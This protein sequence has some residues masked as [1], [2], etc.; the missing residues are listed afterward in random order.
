MFLFWNSTQC[1]RAD[2]L[3]KTLMLGKIEDRGS[4]GWMASLTQ[5]TWVWANSKK[6]W[7]TGKPACCSPWCHKQSDVIEESEHH[8]HHKLIHIYSI[9][10][11]STEHD[12]FFNKHFFKSIVGRRKVKDN[13]KVKFLHDN[14]WTIGCNELPKLTFK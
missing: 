7:R 14:T 10:I 1:K 9:N 5:Q 12:S 6:Q 13:L 4:D 3:E 11:F 8:P 2:S